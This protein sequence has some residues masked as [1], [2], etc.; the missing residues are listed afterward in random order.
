MHVNAPRQNFYARINKCENTLK[1]CEYWYRSQPANIQ[2]QN[3]K[4]FV[5][6]FSICGLRDT[7]GI[8]YNHH[9]DRVW[10]LHA[11]YLNTMVFITNFKKQS[12]HDCW[13]RRSNEEFYGRSGLL[14]SKKF[15]TIFTKNLLGGCEINCDCSSTLARNVS[16]LGI[17][18]RME[19]LYM[20]WNPTVSRRPHCVFC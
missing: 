10:I 15:F 5:L 13:W 2:I 18:I 3:R 12:T 4:R 11:L 19:C 16:L 9:P 1:T 14:D 8:I 6:R 7:D 17:Y 20:E